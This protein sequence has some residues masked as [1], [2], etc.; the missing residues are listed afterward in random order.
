MC[1]FTSP[2]PPHTRS[3]QES[4]NIWEGM[5]A[6]GYAPNT[7]TYNALISAYSKAGMIDKV[8][9][10]LLLL[11][12]PPMLSLLLLQWPLPILLLFLPHPSPRAPTSPY[13]NPHH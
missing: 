4:L 1:V 11:S 8:S 5:S 9:T 13:P 2:L 10:N 12:L 7:T 3:V 6:Q